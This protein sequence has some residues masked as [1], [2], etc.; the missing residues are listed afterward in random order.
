MARFGFHAIVG[1]ACLLVAAC[2][3]RGAPEDATMEYLETWRGLRAQG[4]PFPAGSDSERQALDR[5]GH[6]FEDLKAPDLDERVRAV[7]AEGAWFNDTLKTV[8]GVDGLARYLGHTADA[9]E[10]GGVEILDVAASDGDYYVRWEMTLR[11]AKI[12]RG[13]THRSVG[14]SH[15]RFDEEGKVVLHQDFWDSTSGLFEHVPGLGWLLR[16]AKNRI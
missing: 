14:V 4:V 15:L 5:F 10:S 16:Q 2:A 7:Y 11:F 1:M 8:E 12:A 13:E 9:L 3:S 6:L